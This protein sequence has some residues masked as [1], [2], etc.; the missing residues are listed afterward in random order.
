MVVIYEQRA[1][2]G[3]SIQE[4]VELCSQPHIQVVVFHNLMPPETL[5]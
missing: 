3:K 4:M 1:H 2:S 5:Q